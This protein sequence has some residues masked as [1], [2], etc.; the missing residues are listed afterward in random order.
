MGEETHIVEHRKSGRSG[1][2][3][4]GYMVA[5]SAADEMRA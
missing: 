3:E 5:V 1:V 4:A 2:G